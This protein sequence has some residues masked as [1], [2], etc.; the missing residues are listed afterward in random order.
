MKIDLNEAA[1]QKNQM[2]IRMQA[3]PRVSK[4]LLAAPDDCQFGLSIQGTYEKDEVPAVPRKECSRP[5]GCICTY[6]PVL[7]TIFP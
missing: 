2:L 3:N 5:G 1:E 6:E 7:N 4:I